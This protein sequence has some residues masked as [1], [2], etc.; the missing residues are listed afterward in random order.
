MEERSAFLMQLKPGCE[1]EYTKRHDEI[2]EDLKNLLTDSG[3]Y[4]YSIYLERSTGRLFAFQKTK[5]Q[6][7]QDLGENPLVRRWWDHMADLME[8][9]P[10]NSPVCIPLDEVFHM[11]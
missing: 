10:D 3:V 8:V 4:V 6:K 7:A 11:D 1:K 5:G 2:W 9:N